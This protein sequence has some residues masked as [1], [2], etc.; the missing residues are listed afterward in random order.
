LSL[1]PV[2]VYPVSLAFF[3]QPDEMSQF[4]NHTPDSPV[5]FMLNSLI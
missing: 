3:L 4:I 2:K 5:V 1:A